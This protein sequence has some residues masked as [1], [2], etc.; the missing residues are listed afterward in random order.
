M[1]SIIAIAAIVVLSLAVFLYF[2][3]RS[4]RRLKKAHESLEQAHGK[5]E[6]THQQLLTAY[7]QLEETTR[8]RW[9][10]A[11][12]RSATTSTSLPR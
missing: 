8:C 7:D 12:S 9:C 5:L 3:I 11:S 10:Q 6:E 1:R 2:R 4:A